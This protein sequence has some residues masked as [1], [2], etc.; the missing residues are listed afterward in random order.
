M[1]Q[2]QEKPHE[3][4][5]LPLGALLDPQCLEQGEEPVQVVVGVRRQEVDPPPVYPDP[6]LPL[7]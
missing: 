5:L 4:R 1:L 3:P 7:P 2:A 6:V